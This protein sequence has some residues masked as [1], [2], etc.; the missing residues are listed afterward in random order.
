MNLNFSFFRDFLVSVFEFSNDRA[1]Q[2]VRVGQIL[3][4]IIA[5]TADL[6]EF[7]EHLGV[8]QHSKAVVVLTKLEQNRVGVQSLFKIVFVF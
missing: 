6:D 4:V 1:K 3:N 8:G 5:L 2:V 7:L